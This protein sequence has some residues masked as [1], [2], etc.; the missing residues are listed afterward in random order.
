VVD[1]VGFHAV[2]ISA[3]GRQRQAIFVNTRLVLSTEFQN[4]QSC[5][6]KKKPYLKQTR[7]KKR[8]KK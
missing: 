8:R 6:K 7:K 3:L 5:T 2:L 4:I 1:S